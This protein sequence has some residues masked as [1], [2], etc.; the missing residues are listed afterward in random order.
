MGNQCCTGEALPE[1]TTDFKANSQ[2][3]KNGQVKENPKKSDKKQTSD[4]VDK[5]HLPEE[6]N[7]T[8]SPF[9]ANFPPGLLPEAIKAELTLQKVT[10]LVNK[11]TTK[12]PESTQAYLNN[13]TKEIYKGQFF[14]KLPHGFGEIY[15]P[16]NLENP[17]NSGLETVNRG[18]TVAIQGGETK[19]K[20]NA[21]YSSNPEILK[22]N[23]YIKYTGC[24]KEGKKSGFGRAV[25]PDGSVYEGEWLDNLPNGKGKLASLT[26]NNSKEF[27]EGEWKLGQ[28]DGKGKQQWRDGTVYEGGFKGGKKDGKGV[29]TWPDGNKYEG[30]YK[31]DLRH[32]SGKFTW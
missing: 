13:T 14:N 4:L 22:V 20:D 7:K 2:T 31:T 30:E 32:G 24:F 17:A 18:N 1:Q 3:S 5:D 26:D 12:Y 10:S 21:T 28:M 6:G 9:T 27:Y 23:S 8:F 25:Y 16:T 11:D 19:Q 15:E 29:F